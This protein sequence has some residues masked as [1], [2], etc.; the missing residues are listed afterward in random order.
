[1]SSHN[2]ISNPAKRTFL[3]VVLPKSKQLDI[4]PIKHNDLSIVGYEVIHKCSYLSKRANLS[5]VHSIQLII[6]IIERYFVGLG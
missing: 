6:C 1:M 2:L 3:A 4:I 5:Q